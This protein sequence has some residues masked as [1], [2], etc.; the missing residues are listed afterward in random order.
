MVLF[1]RLKKREAFGSITAK[2]KKIDDVS[3]PG[4]PRNYPNHGMILQVPSKP[5]QPEALNNFW[6]SEVVRGRS[7]RCR[8][9]SPDGCRCRLPHPRQPARIHPIS[10]ARGEE[11]AWEGMGLHFFEGF[12][13][14]FFRRDGHFCG[15]FFFVLDCVLSGRFFL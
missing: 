11:R 12:F 8:R 4:I 1:R 2:V 5:F 14:D 3:G 10:E 13:V 7:Q 9:I 15:R 6:A